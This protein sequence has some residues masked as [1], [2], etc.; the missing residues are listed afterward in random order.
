MVLFSFFL[1]GD[2]E[3]VGVF[4]FFWTMFKH[5]PDRSED[6][7][8]MKKIIIVWCGVNKNGFQ[9]NESLLSKIKKVDNN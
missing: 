8:V 5:P 1:F 6:L 7:D 4:F 2:S 3:D 9:L